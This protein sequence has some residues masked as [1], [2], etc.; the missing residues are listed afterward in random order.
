MQKSQDGTAGGTLEEWRSESHDF[1]GVVSP[2]TIFF[3]VH[4]RGK[5]GIQPLDGHREHGPIGGISR[6][7]RHEAASTKV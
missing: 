1:V 3:S 6:F 7:V 4:R 5:F 2:E